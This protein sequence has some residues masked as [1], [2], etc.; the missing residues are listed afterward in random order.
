M[1]ECDVSVPNA[2]RT[3]N[4]FFFWLKRMFQGISSSLL[5]PVDRFEDGR[6]EGVRKSVDIKLM[7]C[8]NK[9]MVWKWLTATATGFYRE[10]QIITLKKEPIFIIHK[11]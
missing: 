10:I 6:W 11:S 5:S 7:F 3:L 9:I 8:C 4:A 2:G 1:V